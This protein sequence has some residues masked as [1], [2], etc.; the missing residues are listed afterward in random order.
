MVQM[1]VQVHEGERDRERERDMDRKMHR[2]MIM[3]SSKVHLI[4]TTTIIYQLHR[5]RKKHKYF[6]QTLHFNATDQNT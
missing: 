3:G 4:S 5:C 2:Q 6:I 1:H